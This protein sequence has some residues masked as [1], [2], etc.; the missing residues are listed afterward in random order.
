MG[1][2]ALKAAV[3]STQQECIIWTIWYKIWRTSALQ[4]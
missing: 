4:E 1:H 3:E 2:K